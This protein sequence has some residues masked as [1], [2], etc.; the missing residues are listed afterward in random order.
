[1]PDRID[2]AFFPQQLSTWRGAHPQATLTEIE[3]EVDRLLAV[4][5]TQTVRPSPTLVPP[6]PAA[7]SGARSTHATA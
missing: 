4:F 2:V 1:M 6:T 5:R 7:L 3:A